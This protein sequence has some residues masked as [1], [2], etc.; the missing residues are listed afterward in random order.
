MEINIDEIVSNVR[1][2][3]G[4]TLLTPQLMRKIV[5]AVL[6]AVEEREDHRDRVRIEQRVTR[7]VAYE[8]EQS[9]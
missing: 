3:D 9:S 2:M 7:G 4:E 5:E 1:V 8:L 6:R